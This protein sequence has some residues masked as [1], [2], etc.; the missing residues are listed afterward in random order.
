MATKPTRHQ[1]QAC[2]HFAEALYLITLGA[3]LDGRGKFEAADLNEV[4]RRLAEASPAFGLDGIVARAL[5]RRVAALGLS[6]D[7]ADL[8]T[9][10]EA[11]IK[12]LEMLLLD[13]EEFLALVE[14]LREELGE[15]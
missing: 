3:R 4:A 6:S 15:F 7:T 12:P 10:M 1:Q 9:L 11:D 5:G 8:L 14:R 2:E 13:D